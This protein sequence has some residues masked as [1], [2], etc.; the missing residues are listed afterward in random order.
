MNGLYEQMLPSHSQ[1]QIPALAQSYP[2]GIQPSKLCTSVEDAKSL[3]AEHV[4]S[5]MGLPLDGKLYN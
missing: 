1:V 5:T 2:A 4:L 3:A